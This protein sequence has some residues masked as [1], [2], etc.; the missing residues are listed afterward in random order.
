MPGL[1]IKGAGENRP[2]FIRDLS[3]AFFGSLSVLGGCEA[4]FCDREAVVKDIQGAIEAAA[5]GRTQNP[6]GPASP[7]ALQ[8]LSAERYFEDSSGKNLTKC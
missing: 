5:I 3:A 8:A 2:E 6:R 7:Y 1:N 4:L